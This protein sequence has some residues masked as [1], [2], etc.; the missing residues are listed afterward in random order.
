MTDFS[1][2]SPLR[3]FSTDKIER[4]LA[5]HK[6]YLLLVAGFDF[7]CSVKYSVGRVAT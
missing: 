2:G 6:L 7:G 1:A 5:E 4:M 3:R